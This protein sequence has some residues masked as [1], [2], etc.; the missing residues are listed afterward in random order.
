VPATHD[1]EQKLPAVSGSS[2]RL[3]IEQ[4]KAEQSEKDWPGRVFEDAS[5]DYAQAMLDFVA[6]SQAKSE[7]GVTENTAESLDQ[8]SLK[9]QKRALRQEEEA[10]RAERRVARQRRE[11]EDVAWQ[12]MRADR[13]QEREAPA[14]QSAAQRETQRQGWRALRQQRQQTVARREQEDAEW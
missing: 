14:G 5:R 7:P 2:G 13:K 10:L 12:R 8:G 4:P 6:A 11:Q 1:A 3:V 9:A